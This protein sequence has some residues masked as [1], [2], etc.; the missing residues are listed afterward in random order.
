MLINFPE[1]NVAAE[2][3]RDKRITPGKYRAPSDLSSGCATRP[4]RVILGSS[5]LSSLRFLRLGGLLDNSGAITEFYYLEFR[6]EGRE[7]GART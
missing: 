7:G 4:A 3:S 5:A 2:I 1:P 6:Q